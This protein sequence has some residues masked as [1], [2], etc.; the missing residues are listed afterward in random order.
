ML[1]PLF[2][3]ELCWMLF[4]LYLLSRLSAKMPKKNKKNS[5]KRLA[6]F[7]FAKGAA[8]VCIIAIHA[9][10]LIPGTQFLKEYLWFGLYLFFITSG[11]LLSIRYDENIDMKRYARNVFIRII[12]LYIAAVVTI[13]AILHQEM[14]LQEITLDIIYGRTNG[15]YYFIPIL[16]QFYILFPLFVKLKKYLFSWLMPLILV[17]SYGFQLGNYFLQA[18]EWNS[19]IL[20]LVFFG[21]FAFFFFIGMALSDYDLEKIKKKAIAGILLI[22]LLSA[23]IISYYAGTFYPTYM[24]PV[25]AFIALILIYNSAIKGTIASVLFQKIGEIS[26][27]I[28]LVHTRVMY[29]IIGKYA[30]YFRS[31]WMKYFFILI[32]TILLSFL[33]SKIISVVYLKMLELIGKKLQ[34][35]KT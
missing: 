31:I 19:N 25:T 6:F 7:D 5:S 20:S 34:S 9:T 30:I 32:A 21:R 33:L 22:Y 14:S 29:D 17:V 12:F 28:Y 3:W 27:M 23:A 11:Y 18:P 24:Y 2:Y 8:M 1:N 16:L 13:R 10:D 26:F 35:E 4:F 15:N